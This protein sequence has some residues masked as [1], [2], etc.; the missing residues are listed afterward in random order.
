MEQKL[1]AVVVTDGPATAERIT[2]ILTADGTVEVVGTFAGEKEAVVAIEHMRFDLVVTGLQLTQGTGFGVIRAARR[3][4]GRHPVVAV[5]TRHAVPALRV[6]A[7][8]SGA[9]LFLDK[10]KG[11]AQ[12]AAV[13][14]EAARRATPQP[15]QEA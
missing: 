10:S 9:D 1:Q 15:H 6:A 7:A 3:S 12:L 13:V 14:I 4:L 5:F 8:E 11:A 2:E